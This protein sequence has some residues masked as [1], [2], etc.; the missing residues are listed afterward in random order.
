MKSVYLKLPFIIVTIVTIIFSSCEK[1]I[2]V[3]PEVQIEV[4]NNEFSVIDGYL[5]FN[6]NESFI[7]TVNS[8]S[9]HTLIERAAWEK[10]MGFLSQRT[11]VNTIIKDQNE[12]DKVNE[13]KYAGKK[14][15]E[16]DRYE[17]NPGSYHKY[18][19]KGVIKVINEGTK[20]EFWEIASFKPG[21]TSFLNEDG[22][23]AIGDTLYQVTNNAVKALKD[24]NFSKNAELLKNATETDEANNIYILESK[25]ESKYNTPGWIQSEW[26]E[27]Y[28]MGER[29]RISIY[30]DVYTFNHVLS[31]WYYWHSFNIQYQI[32]NWLFIWRYRDTELD[33][34]G[35]W[36]IWMYKNTEHLTNNL[37]TTYYGGYIWMSIDPE[38]GT[39][40]PYDHVF[41]RR[42]QYPYFE[43]HYYPP[44]FDMYDWWVEGGQSFEPRSVHLMEL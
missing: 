16:I 31:E 18:L 21:L 5:S 43:D 7:E 23:F 14:L 26:D 4:T 2:E 12:L 39:I 22:L 40:Y 36:D 42:A 11:I 44:K 10:K 24:K 6:S 25:S 41:F 28:W 17:L 33:V 35:W 30:L 29:L 8:I 9:S 3:Q 37:Y 20:D 34:I 27:D 13:I 32:R 38:D 1:Q 15:E 19:K